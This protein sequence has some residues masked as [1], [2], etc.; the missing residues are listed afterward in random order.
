MGSAP[1]KKRPDNEL[2]LPLSREDTGGGPSPGTART[3]RA[4]GPRQTSELSISSVSNGDRE[5]CQPKSMRRLSSS[6][7]QTAPCPRQLPW[8]LPDRGAGDWQGRRKFRADHLLSPK[9]GLLPA[10]A[11]PGRETGTSLRSHDLPHCGPALYWGPGVNGAINPKRKYTRWPRSACP[12]QR[13]TSSLLGNLTAPFRTSEKSD[14]E[15]QGTNGKGASQRW[16]ESRKRDS[17]PLKD[18]GLC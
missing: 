6:C 16:L 10:L 12:P 2:A 5:S 11:S 18:L 4:Q 1:D 15:G 14:F 13:V 17:S 9:V 3:P 8:I 7:S